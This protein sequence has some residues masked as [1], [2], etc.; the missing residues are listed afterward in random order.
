MFLTI[1]TAN[2]FNCSD[3]PIV[4]QI[5][6]ITNCTNRSVIVITALIIYLIKVGIDGNISAIIY[7]NDAN[8]YRHNTITCI[9]SIF[10]SIMTWELV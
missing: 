1:E 2:L 4:Q 5:K 9:V 7:P 3:E 10:F 6:Q 8:N